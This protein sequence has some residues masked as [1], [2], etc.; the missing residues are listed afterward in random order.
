MADDLEVVIE[1]LSRSGRID[2]DAFDLLLPPG[3]PDE[4]PD[5][6]EQ[7]RA[8]LR[9]RPTLGMEQTI[10]APGTGAVINPTPVPIAPPED[11]Y[12]LGDRLG[13]GGVGE[14]FVASDR[15]LHRDV[16]LK[17]LRAEVQDDD[18]TRE[19]FVF[20][21]RMT[22]RL[23]HPGI[24]PVYDLGTLPDGRVFYTMQRLPG[25][26][27][28]HVLEGLRAGDSTTATDYPLPRLLSI[29]ARVCMTVAY[30]HARDLTHRD[31]KPEN[32]LL[33]DYG[34]VYVGDWGLVK[35][36]DGGIGRDTV[37][38]TMMGTLHYMSPEQVRGEPDAIGPAADVWALGVILYELLTLDLPFR[39]SSA[40]AV[41]FRI[42]QGEV[43][44][45]EGTAER[46]V[47]DALAAL[48]RQALTL[49]PAERELTAREMG[50]AIARFLDGVEAQ[51]RRRARGAEMSSR[52][53]ALWAELID[54]RAAVGEAQ[55]AV[56]RRREALRPS[57]PM[58]DRVAV[59][60][61][62]QA[63]EEQRLAVERLSTR[64]VQAATGALEE[65]ETDETHDLLARL[66]LDRAREAEARRDA[67]ARLHFRALAARHDR[68][69]VTA[70]L[71]DTGGLRI[72]AAAGARV[73]LE[74]LVPY[75]PVLRAE[76]AAPD[77]DLAALPIGPWQVRVEQP[78]AMPATV[79][80]R[81]RGGEVVRLPL[82]PPP[83]FEG[84]DAF[85]W[86]PAGTYPLGG[87]PDAT[88]ALPARTATLDAFLLGRFP[89]T[90]AEYIA[91]LDALAAREGLAAAL[92]RAPRSSD[93]SVQYLH[94]DAARARFSVP[95][96]D[97]DGDAWHP[98]WPVVAVS[99]ADAEAYCAW[100]TEVTGAAHR[101]PT[102]DEWEAAAR[103]VDERLFPWGNGF[104]PALCHMNE[105]VDGP[106]VPVPV[107]S[108]AYDQSPFG[109][110]D[111]AGLVIEW[112]ASVLADGQ[113]VQRGAASTSPAA[114]CRAA[115][116][117]TQ[118]GDWVAPQF[119]F[120]VAR[121]V[122][123]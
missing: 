51:R 90:M 29:L 110:R 59:W 88:Q 101:L 102:E 91:F 50:E 75:G 114:W 32:L 58:T 49:R 95:E 23:T 94:H 26:T 118:R 93:G 21:A 52:A 40:V 42:S 86:I 55:R 105:S 64:A 121:A 33:G 89:V 116:R 20:E 54:A 65:W 72:D 108:Y 25:R 27:L 111:M 36:S 83:L 79:P 4:L 73:A 37:P 100:R 120:R 115:S 48:C 30:A 34:E 70:A 76:P 60:Q 10:V 113:R 41:L 14:V 112:T 47:P 18:E 57:T 45:L 98:D 11:R 38:G 103:G 39:G 80:V 71:A 43:P 17:V 96:V 61:A 67:A 87:D 81:V 56:Q 13:R 104:D 9:S 15:A 106:R 74:R 109:V 97:D 1:R 5:R 53:R 44:P 7:V 92:A 46:P 24:I 68:G 8:L 123:R 85:V 69:A 31:L 62:T 28:H 82:H 78:A 22:G 35:H 122:P 84:A 77:V 16:A 6:V 117:R 99:A 19:R 107:G 63:L 119:G 66:Y 12:A 2:A 3:S